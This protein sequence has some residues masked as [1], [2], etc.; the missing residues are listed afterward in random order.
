MPDPNIAVIHKWK[1]CFLFQP[2]VA[3]S[4]SKIAI[5]ESL[6]G[7][8]DQHH[9]HDPILNIQGDFPSQVL[10]KYPDYIR[11]AYVRHPFDRLVSCY[12]NKIVDKFHGG[13][14][15]PPY[16]MYHK[17]PFD[18]FAR[19]VC[20]HDDSTADLHLRSQSWVTHAGEKICFNYLIKYETLTEDWNRLR[21]MIPGLKTLPHKNKTERKPWREYF[22]K[23][24]KALVFSHYIK[25]FEH[26]NYNPEID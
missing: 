20:R 13:L 15:R 18:E 12:H 1:T 19:E 21:L 9:Q 24:L 16:K 7:K 23:E 5:I 26:F 4:S 6:G 2:K 11:V 17:M 10:E 14:A 8:V 25:D 3:N 22:T